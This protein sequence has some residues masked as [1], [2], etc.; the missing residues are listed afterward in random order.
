MTEPLHTLHILVVDDEQL[1]RLILEETLSPHY[2]VHIAKDGV[3][4]LTWL[5]SGGPA[6]LILSD[7]VM[8]RMDGFELCRRL[9]ADERTQDIPLLFLTSLDSEADEEA[10][11]TLGAEDFIHKPISPPIVLARVRNHLE[12]AR[13]R[14][15]LHAR[16]ADLELIVLERTQAL[17]EQ[18]QQVITAQGAIITAFCTLAE[19]RDNETGNHILRTQRYVEV[20][21][22][23]LQHHPRFA[24]ELDDE[25]I[26]LLFKSAPLHDIGKVGIPDA[27]LLKPGK[28]TEEEW[29]IMRRHAEFG[30][31]AILQAERNL[32]TTAAGFLSHAYDIAWCHH[33][34]WDGSGYPR[35]LT[36]TTI[37]LSARLMAVADVYDALI[38]RR[39]YKPPFPHAQAIAMILEGKNQH[40]DPDIVD[41]LCAIEDKFRAIAADHH[42][43]ET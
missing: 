2:T 5:Q 39:V 29:V 13:T 25:T 18:K 34:K 24:P 12:L 36:G 9:K 14:A 32:G 35:G 17:I 19:T 23:R 33:E 21:A 30:R 3:E 43:E 7:V 11:L 37:P 20:L 41:A 27:I 6:E 8:P 10:G 28:L 4:A 31:D 38:S 40:F 16:N 15:Q 22:Q 1:N 42:D 26:A